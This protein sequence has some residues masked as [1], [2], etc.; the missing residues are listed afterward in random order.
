MSQLLNR[1]QLTEL[2]GVR[3]ST[4]GYLV[5]TGR[6]PKPIKV[7]HHDLR[8]PMDEI[9]ATLDKMRED[10]LTETEG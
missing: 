6:L 2:L 4:I 3:L 5:K 1:S 7:T 8:W 9:Q 10:R